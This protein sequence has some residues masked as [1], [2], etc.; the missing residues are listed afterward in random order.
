MR[1]EKVGDSDYIPSFEQYCRGQGMKM[2]KDYSY[3][4]ETGVLIKARKI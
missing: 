2:A 4:D 1:E 3:H